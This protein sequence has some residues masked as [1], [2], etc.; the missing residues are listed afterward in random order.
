MQIYK[1][2]FGVGGPWWTASLTG[3][4]TRR[5]LAVLDCTSNILIKA[6]LAL[7]QTRWHLK[8]A[9]WAEGTY[10]PSPGLRT[11][12]A[13]NHKQHRTERGQLYLREENSL[14][15]QPTTDCGITLTG[16]TSTGHGASS[17]SPD[18]LSQF[19]HVFVGGSQ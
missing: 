8:A 18:F 14:S 11:L 6:C 17:P 3:A 10:P 12:A 15:V 7:L 4:E 13:G 1:T 2:P 19:Y 5:R 16:P 9:A